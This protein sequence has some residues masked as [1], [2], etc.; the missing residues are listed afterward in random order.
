MTRCRAQT[1][2]RLLQKRF[3]IAAL[4]CGMA[5]CASHIH[6]IDNTRHLSTAEVDALCADLGTRANLDCQWNMESRPS[7]VTD[8]QT[9]EINCRSRRDV[10]QQSFDNVC[11]PAARALRERDDEPR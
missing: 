10:A 8:Q 3:A 9:W 5:G 6:T 4:A 7:E 1:M 11:N 2:F